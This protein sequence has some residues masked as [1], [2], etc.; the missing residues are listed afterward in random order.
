MRGVAG[1]AIPSKEPVPGAVG[2]AMP[3]TPGPSPGGR[4][5]KDLPVVPGSEGMCR[6]VS[7]EGEGAGTDQLLKVAVCWLL[8]I[9]LT[10]WVKVTCLAGLASLP[11]LLKTPGRRVLTFEY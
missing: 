1:R 11:P 4:G 2:E 6:V 7:P 5:E 8:G 10:L 3:L 9:T